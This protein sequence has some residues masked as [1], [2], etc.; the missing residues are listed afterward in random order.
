MTAAGN[1]KSTHS[2]GG[3]GFASSGTATGDDTAGGGGGWYGGGS[4]GD[5]A[6]G[7]GSSFVWSNDH[8]S[9]VPSG[10]TPSA[11]Y[12]M[13]NISCTANTNEGNGKAKITNNT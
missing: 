2:P 5:S 7:G 9:Y 12:K 10:Y 4:G 13:T 11:S 3:F 8:A 6:G 1:N